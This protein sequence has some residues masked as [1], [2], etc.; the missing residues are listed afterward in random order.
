MSLVES[1]PTMTCVALRC[2]TPGVD[3]TVSCI[4][5]ELDKRTFQSSDISSQARL[6]SALLKTCDK[7]L[8]SADRTSPKCNG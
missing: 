6:V 4:E 1:T 8:S 7:W 2:N 3:R 5:T